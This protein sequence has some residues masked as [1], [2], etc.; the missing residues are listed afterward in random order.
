MTAMLEVR[1]RVS[2][3]ESEQVEF[4]S[5]MIREGGL[6]N[7]DATRPENVLDFI[8]AIAQQVQVLIATCHGER[9]RGIGTAI[10]IAD[11]SN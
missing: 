7:T 9:Y 5:K 11:E 2:D 6:V 3:G 10:R 4:R 8:G 1:K